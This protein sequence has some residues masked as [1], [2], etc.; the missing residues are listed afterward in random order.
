MPPLYLREFVVKS[1]KNHWFQLLST[2]N[3]LSISLFLIQNTLF[4]SQPFCHVCCWRRKKLHASMK[5]LLLFS[6]SHLTQKKLFFCLL[7]VFLFFVFAFWPIETTTANMQGLT[8][9]NLLK[10]TNQV[11]LSNEHM[12]HTFWA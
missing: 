7:S 12:N 5:A 9:T 1:T 3:E 4:I 6:P 2:K 8:H 11:T 10:S